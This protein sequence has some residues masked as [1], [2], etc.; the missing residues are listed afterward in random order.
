MNSKKKWL[1]SIAIGAFVMVS[2]MAYLILYLFYSMERLPEGELIGES[3]SPSKEY[4]VKIF[5]GDIGK[6]RQLLN[7]LMM[8]Q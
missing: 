3:V 5:I 2:I 4:T 1:I 6:M 8:T 7:G